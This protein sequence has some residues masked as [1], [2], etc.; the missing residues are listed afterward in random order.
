VVPDKAER[1]RRFQASTMEALAE[2]TAA[3]GVTHPADISREQ[4]MRR[5]MTGEVLSFAEVYPQL[6]PGSLIEGT[7]G[8]KYARQW[9][10]ADAGSFRA[11][12][13]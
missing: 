12:V 6:A 4:L 3:A 5:T 9:A 10:M 1:V 7:A 8:G 11:R 2:L 13:G